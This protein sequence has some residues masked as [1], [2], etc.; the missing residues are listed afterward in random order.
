MAVGNKTTSLEQEIGQ[1]IMILRGGETQEEVAK[2]IGVSREIIQHW[3]RGTRHIKAGHLCALAKH[4]GKSVDYIV[5]LVDESNSTND[6]KLRAASEYT[7]LSNTAVSRLRE[8]SEYI[9]AHPAGFVQNPYNVLLAFDGP[10]YTLQPDD[11]RVSSSKVFGVSLIEYLHERSTEIPPDEIGA[12]DDE[13][14]AEILS[15]S[16]QLAAFGYTVAAKQE[17]TESKLQTA[18]DALKRLFWEYCDKMREVEKNGK[19]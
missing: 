13:I 9:K 15:I 19:H 10:E 7:G 8:L 16:E 12:I 4:F 1:R 14:N 6:E 2:A 11:K 3:E 5:G 17:V 18:C